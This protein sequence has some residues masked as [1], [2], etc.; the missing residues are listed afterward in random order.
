MFAS[1][2]R[3][4]KD[5]RGVGSVRGDRRVRVVAREIECAR[6]GVRGV[7][8]AARGERPALGALPGRGARR[9]AGLLASQDDCAAYDRHVAE[10]QVEYVPAGWD[11]CVAEYDGPCDR[12]MSNCFYEILHGLVADGQHCQDDRGVRDLLRVLLGRRRDVRRG[13]RPRPEGERKVRVALR[14]QRDAVCRPPGLLLRSELPGRN[15]RQGEGHRRGLR[16]RRSGSVLVRAALHGGSRRSHQH[17]H[18]SAARGGRAVPRRQRLPGHR[19]LPRGHAAPRSA[20]PWAQSCA[21]APPS[22]VP[23]TVCDAGGVCAPAGR[24]GL[25]C[26]PFPGVAL[27]P[28]LRDRDLRR[29][30]VRR[31]REP[32]RRC[33]LGACAPGSSCDLLTLTCVACPP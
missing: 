20:A 26:A 30:H 25:P 29:H 23:W 11:A 17:R 6:D 4:E 3:H 13:L 33:G 31:E 8:G 12:I 16:R 2:G 10:H 1:R 19:V 21:D 22:C 9:L 15:L 14:R 24:P 27:L 28:G 32:R 7:H 5:R 18:L